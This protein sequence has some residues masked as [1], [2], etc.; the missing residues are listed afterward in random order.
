MECLWCLLIL[1]ILV[2]GGMGFGESWVC[3]ECV[4]HECAFTKSHVFYKARQSEKKHRY[5]RWH[6]NQVLLYICRYINTPTLDTKVAC[7]IFG[8]P[9]LDTNNE[10]FISNKTGL[11]GKSLS[12]VQIS[13][14]RQ[15]SVLVFVFSDSKTSGLAPTKH[16]PCKYLNICSLP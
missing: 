11:R 7:K 13:I 14:W 8:N 12:S 15:V 9:A 1:L 6:S 16:I 4:F 5:F 10:I 3:L 2:F